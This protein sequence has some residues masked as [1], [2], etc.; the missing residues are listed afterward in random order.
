MPHTIKKRWA[1]FGALIGVGATLMLVI[2][3]GVF[4]GAGAAASSAKPKNTSPPTVAG[5]A[6]EG[7]K[8]TG[9]RG[10]WSGNPV[11]LQPL[12]VALRQ[13]RGELL[14]DQRGELEELHAR[15][16]RRRQHAPVQGRR[17]ERRRHDV[18]VVGSDR[19][20]HRREQAAAVD[21]RRRRLRP[22][23]RAARALSRWPMSG[24]RRGC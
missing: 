5:T 4:A 9:D 11:G 15:L 7:E 8:L 14:E 12:L 17:E 22:A 21:A 1:L 13:D 18:R 10:D 19:R 23:V 20:G 16:G 6:Q 3:I 24:R 2:G